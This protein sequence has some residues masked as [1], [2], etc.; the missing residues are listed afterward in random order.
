MVD[1]LH[2]VGAKAT[3][4]DVYD[5]LTVP[6]RLA[7]WWTTD[8]RGTGKVGDVLSFHFGD[9]GYFDMLVEDAE[10]AKHVKW[11][12]VDGPEEWI[13]TTVTFDLSEADGF[14]IVL[15]SHAGWRE[16]VEF[17]H[18]CSTKWATFLMSMKELLETGTA[19]PYPHDLRVSNWG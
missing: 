3:R 12:V 6:N 2:R 14:T 8:T 13:D 7:A 5:A 10:P 1:I 4:D 19:S 16:P 15:F 18:H 17:M 11:R 9:N